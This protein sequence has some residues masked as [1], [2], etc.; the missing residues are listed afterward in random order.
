MLDAVQKDCLALLNDY[1]FKRLMKEIEANFK[2]ASFNIEEIFF[3]DRFS[4]DTPPWMEISKR[5]KAEIANA[6][7]L[8]DTIEK[9]KAKNKEI[10]KQ[11]LAH[12]NNIN[13]NKVT[14]Q[15]HEKKLAQAQTRIEE[16]NH[17]KGENEQ[18]IK[19]QASLKK[20]FEEKHKEE[21]QLKK[22]LDEAHKKN[23]DLEQKLATAATAAPVVSP[24]TAEPSHEEKLGLYRKRRETDN[25][26][27]A[28]KC[29]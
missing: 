24:S 9:L 23:L 27:R 6:E 20:Q 16:L 21:L 22:A 13:R 4:S 3:V 11:N 5:V 12:E 7:Q 26:S 19:Q 25:K 17:V 1:K 14:I 28:S 18:M 10:L 15:S 2:E 8:K 29:T